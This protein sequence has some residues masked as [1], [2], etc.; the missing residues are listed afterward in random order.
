M[1]GCACQRD[2][3]LRRNRARPRETG[4]LRVHATARQ[5]LDWPRAAVLRN[6]PGFRGF[7]SAAATNQA[8]HGTSGRI[9]RHGV[10]LSS[11]SSSRTR[12][13]VA[14]SRRQRVDPRRLAASAR[15]GL[16]ATLAPR[17]ASA[18]PESP[19]SLKRAS[20]PFEAASLSTSAAQFPFRR[21][22]SP[23]SEMGDCDGGRNMERTISS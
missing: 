2:G 4:D 9:R 17:R 12:S 20:S 16:L 14:S 10:R 18:E 11:G 23:V 7:R 13:F 1:C 22:S 15:L 5:S 21:P 19:P 6:S 8:A 3:L